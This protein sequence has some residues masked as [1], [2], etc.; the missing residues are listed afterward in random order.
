MKFTV[1]W[2]PSALNDLADLWNNAPDRSDV[3]AAADAI[4]YALAHNPQSVGEG[5]NDDRR[6]LFIPPLA[7]FF[8]VDAANHHVIV[9][10]VWRWPK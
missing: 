6:I 3:T 10:D 7:V 2:V 1:E 5:R 9:L 8:E 4:D